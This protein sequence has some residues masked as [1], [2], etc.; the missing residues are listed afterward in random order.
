MSSFLDRY[1]LL[2]IVGVVEVV[3]PNLHC[4]I[5]RAL[6]RIYRRLKIR[7]IV[8]KYI[9][10]GVIWLLTLLTDIL[11]LQLTCP[12]IIKIL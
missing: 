8:A 4:K 12:P 3:A 2:T 10:E 6:T 7:C 5:P 11:T 9:F 1:V